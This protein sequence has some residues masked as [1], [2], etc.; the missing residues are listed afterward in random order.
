[1]IT[2]WDLVMIL[3]LASQEPS[4]SPIARRTGFDRKTVRR[5]IQRGL[6]PPANTPR[7]LRLSRLSP[8]EPCLP[9]RLTTAPELTARRLHGEINEQGY[10]GGYPLGAGLCPVRA[11]DTGQAFRASV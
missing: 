11:T 6:E 8:G 2:L 7:P 3:D 10:K 9:E 4:V 5:Y 1:M